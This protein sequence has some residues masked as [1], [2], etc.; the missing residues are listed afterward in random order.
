MS[1]PS[2][3]DLRQNPQIVRPPERERR[4]AQPI[5]VGEEPI[6]LSRFPLVGPEERQ[7]EAVQ[8]SLIV[9]Q[10]AA[11]DLDDAGS[12]RRP[13]RRQRRGQASNGVSPSAQVTGPSD[14]NRAGAQR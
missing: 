12:C 5:E 14:A 10:R 13:A 4:I 9:S 1:R 7:P 3:S 6:A 2:Q 8:R 11:V